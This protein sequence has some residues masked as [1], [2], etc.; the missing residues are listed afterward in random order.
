MMQSCASTKTTRE[1]TRVRGLERRVGENFQAP[2]VE[3]KYSNGEALFE[4]RHDRRLDDL[5]RQLGHQAAHAGNCF[6]VLEPA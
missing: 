5:T 3:L 4:V 1:V 2:C 6:I